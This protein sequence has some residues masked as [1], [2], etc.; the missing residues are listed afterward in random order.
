MGSHDG[1]SKMGTGPGVGKN[2]HNVDFVQIIPNSHFWTDIGMLLE[3]LK[4]ANINSKQQIIKHLQI[5]LINTL[6]NGYNIQKVK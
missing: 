6:E 2:F 4:Y 5:G 1:I 3:W